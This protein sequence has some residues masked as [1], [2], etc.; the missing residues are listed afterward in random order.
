[1]DTGTRTRVV[2]RMAG[3]AIAALLA[4]GLTPGQAAAAPSDRQIANARAAA[5]ELE[6]RIK[7]LSGRL[8]A[9]QTAVEQARVE[10]ALALDDY[11]A[12]QER[13]EAAHGRAVAAAAA[14]RKAA[15]DVGVAHDEVVAFARRSYMQG[16]TYSGAAALLTA[17]DPGQLIERA[18]LLEAAG[19]HRSD[20]LD[21]MEVAHEQAARAEG[22]ART[23]LAEADALK[24]ESAQALARA[25]SAE[26]SARAQAAA[27]STQQTQLRR[28]LSAARSQ[29][30]SLVGAREAANRAARASAAVPPPPRPAPPAPAPVDNGAPAG[31]G[32]ASAAGGTV[33]SGPRTPMLPVISGWIWQA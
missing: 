20:V 22:Q 26:R 9:A 13:F 33:P 14:A 15:A 12:T 4:V 18:A 1:V 11:Q 10:S 21:R 17:A 23:A 8:G 19:A 28:Q 27:L 30:S 29:L 32:S 24:Q 25:Q 3:T 6:A 2:L 5:N 16:S 7:G 31:G